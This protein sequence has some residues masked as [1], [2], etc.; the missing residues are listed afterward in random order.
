MGC[1]AASPRPSP[2]P[3]SKLESVQKWSVSA[4]RLLGCCGAAKA[5]L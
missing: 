1:S 5:G 4:A 2:D 3:L